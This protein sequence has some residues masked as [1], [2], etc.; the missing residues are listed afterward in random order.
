MCQGSELERTNHPEA[1]GLI[2]D[3][4]CPESTKYGHYFVL[5]DSTEG[6]TNSQYTELLRRLLDKENIDFI[7]PYD[8]LTIM[9]VDGRNESA[10][11]MPLFSECKPRSSYKGTMYP[12]NEY[13]SRK[14]A[15]LIL[16]G[17]FIEFEEMLNK[18]TEPLQT[19]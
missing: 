19:K 16:E 3:S 11:V 15:P 8:K 14:D 2:I 17:N 1:D 10:K 4:W 7:A 12:I 6:Y 9:N 18:N 5:I 13:I